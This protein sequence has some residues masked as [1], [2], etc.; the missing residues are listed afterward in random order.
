MS[1]FLK[2]SSPSFTIIEL[3]IVIAIIGLL[4]GIIFIAGRGQGES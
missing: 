1:N 3:L 4:A 2:K